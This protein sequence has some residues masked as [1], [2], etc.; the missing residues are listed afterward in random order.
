MLPGI[1]YGDVWVLVK[2]AKVAPAPTEGRAIGRLDWAVNGSQ[3]ILDRLSATKLP[4]RVTRV[5]QDA[6]EIEIA[7]PDRDRIHA[8]RVSHR[9]LVL[10]DAGAGRDRLH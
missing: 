7:G 5:A 2:T 8:D 1:R 4:H 3:E 9:L 6:K 10:R